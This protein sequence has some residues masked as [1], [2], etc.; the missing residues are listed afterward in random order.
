MTNVTPATGV[1]ELNRREQQS[2]LEASSGHRA[3]LMHEALTGADDSQKESVLERQRRT[4]ELAETVLEKLMA[5]THEEVRELQERMEEL[6]TESMEA[7]AVRNQALAASV[8]E[9]QRSVE[10][11]QHMLSSESEAIGGSSLYKRHELMDALTPASDK[12][13]PGNISKG[14]TNDCNVQYTAADSSCLVEKDKNDAA[15]RRAHVRAALKRVLKPATNIVSAV[16]YAS[17]STSV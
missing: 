6:S 10:H 2:I 9:A 5:M 16:E 3:T 13:K 4:T 12:P 8:A 14:G 1:S 17:S 11:V 7:L 15:A